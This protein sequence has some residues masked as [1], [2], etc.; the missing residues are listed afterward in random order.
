MAA[1]K[2]KS[3]AKMKSKAK[4]AAKA[5][6]KPAAKSKPV[7]KAKAAAK[8]APK[9]KLMDKIKSKLGMGAK[10]KT[11][12]APGSASKAMPRM[13]LNKLSPLEDRIVV[14]ID[15]AEEKTAGGL[16]IPNSAGVRPNS[17][18]VLAA[19][20]GKRN[21]KGQMRPLD[22]SVGDKVLFPEYAGTKIEFDKDEF[23]VLREDEVLGIVT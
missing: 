13:L 20:P 12:T 19:G 4:P 7:M 8:P 1:S 6:T 15:G 22:V 10:S 9:T 3:K 18:K 21:K 11:S 16:Y 23:L 2:N 5:K 14:A 17:G